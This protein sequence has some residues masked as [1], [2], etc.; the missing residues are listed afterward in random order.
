[1]I[2]FIKYSGDFMEIIEKVLSD[3]EHEFLKITKEEINVHPFK[4]YD[5]MKI[6][7]NPDV[8]YIRDTMM[9]IS[10]LKLSKI[11]I[12]DLLD[13]L[14]KYY[15]CKAITKIINNKEFIIVYFKTNFITD[16]FKNKTDW[17]Y[18]DYYFTLKNLSIKN[19]YLM[20]SIKYLNNQYEFKL[21]FEYEN[22]LY[23]FSD[24][25][26]FNLD[27]DKIY[28]IDYKYEKRKNGRLIKVDYYLSNK[29]KEEEITNLIFEDNY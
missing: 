19:V 16:I 6:F 29:L 21:I 20:P 27:I 3:I 26:Y 1:M 12:F 25:D 24:S 9:I 23:Y 10:L 17:M 11:M 4:I 15:K 18:V 2:V 28:Y 7:S 5:L 8:T 22:K 14:K 13:L